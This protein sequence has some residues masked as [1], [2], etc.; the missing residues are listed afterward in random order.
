MR[1]RFRVSFASWSRRRWRSRVRTC[2]TIREFIHPCLEGLGET[3]GPLVFQFTPQGRDVTRAPDAFINRLYRF[4][5]A[6]PVGPLYAVEI[7]DPE[8]MTKRFFMCLKTTGVHFCVA[9][10]ANMPPIDK[11]IEAMRECM[12]VGPFIA[13]WSLHSGFRYAD[14]KA[15][16]APFDRLIDEDPQSRHTLAQ[17]CLHAVAL[18]QSAFVIVNN[19][20]EGSSP[21]SIVKLAAAIGDA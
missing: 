2:A 18:G 10:H 21:L 6:L 5:K 9:A 8:L 14:A 4:L 13:R 3:A 20:A 12:D 11:Q 19:K 15:R 7:R 16:Y 17:A 1:P